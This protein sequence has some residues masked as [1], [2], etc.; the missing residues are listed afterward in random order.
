MQIWVDADACPKAIK[1]IVFRAA[2][3]LQIVTWLVANSFLYVPASPFIKTV[4]VPAGLDMA[5]QHIIEN[6]QSADL[7]ITADIPL[8]DAVIVKA[9]KALNP[10]GELYT[11]DNIKQCLAMRNLHTEL[12][13]G[14]MISSGTARLSQRDI[15]TFANGLDRFLNSR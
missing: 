12:R 8:A 3:R 7:V 15:Q 9:A 4:R 6:V 5:D 14:G 1:E 11:K 2:N 10:R 13:A